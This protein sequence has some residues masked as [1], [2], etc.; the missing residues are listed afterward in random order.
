[1]A[2]RPRYK[3]KAAAYPVP[4]NESEASGFILRIGVAQRERDRI[5]S[6]MNDRLASIKSEFEAKALPFKIEIEE[7][8]KG[9]AI[10]CEANRDSLTRAGK[11]KF[12]KFSSGEISWRRCPPKVTVRG[13][14]AVIDR[15]RSLKLTHFLRTKE[16][17]NKE[18]MLAEPEI[19]RAIDGIK[20]ASEGEDFVIKPF[21]T[22]LEEIA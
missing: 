20:I 3:T 5:R 18:A 14:R 19:A 4:Q 2:K 10:F 21:E 9:V 15:I 8:T 6:R 16:E 7:R 13:V 11:V 1:M 12:Y 22:D 17:I